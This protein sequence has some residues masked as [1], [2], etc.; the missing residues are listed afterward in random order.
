MR[1]NVDMFCRAGLTHRERIAVANR[2][3]HMMQR[4]HDHDLNLDADTL[5]AICIQC[6][7]YKAKKG[8]R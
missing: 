3:P 2:E 4:L 7:N 1:I 5:N 6:D 8:N